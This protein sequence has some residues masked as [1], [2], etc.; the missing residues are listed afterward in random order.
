MK[1]YIGFGLMML[2]MP[3]T[4]ANQNI[5]KDAYRNYDDQLGCYIGINKI[6]HGIDKFCMVL[7]AH[8]TVPNEDVKGQYKTYYLATGDNI[9]TSHV[10]E[11][12]IGLV[13]EDNGEGQE[14]RIIAE[15]K[16]IGAGSSGYAPTDY[17]FHKIGVN[18]YAFFTETGYTTQGITSGGL[19]I[20][21]DDNG[22]IFT[23][24]I[25]TFYDDSGHV[26][27]DGDMAVIDAKYIV[28]PDNENKMYPIKITMNGNY[29]GKAYDNKSYFL[30]FN[31]KTNRYILPAN[32]PFVDNQSGDLA[33]INSALQGQWATDISLCR[34]PEIQNDQQY[35][36]QVDDQMIN[37]SGWNFGY[38][39]EVLNFNINSAK[40]LQADIQYS[41]FFEA[42]SSEGMADVQLSIT[43]DNRLRWGDEKSD[44][45]F[46]KCALSN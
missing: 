20:V 35:I 18:S 32:Y 45:L 12:N 25:P 46:L 39:A 30:N 5:M 10:S 9:E 38:N 44:M 14:S 15:K 34:D 24:Y 31:G 43:E 37:L 1:E 6:Q 13:I 33:V 23:D 27:E 3:L 28:L 11:G 42:E 16:F 29:Q 22:K 7:K 19:L 36:L 40:E 21:G 17:T 26:A 4:L 2:S 41:T 8:E